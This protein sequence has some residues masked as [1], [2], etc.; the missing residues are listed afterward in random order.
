MGAA[1]PVPGVS[2]APA[3]AESLLPASFSVAGSVKDTAFS[4]YFQIEQVIKL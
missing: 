4:V 3:V 1:R 2:T